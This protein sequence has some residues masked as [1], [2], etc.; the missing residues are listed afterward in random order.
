[1]KKLTQ[2]LVIVIAC[3]AFTTRGL[4]QSGVLID[5]YQSPTTFTVTGGGAYCAGGIGVPVGVSNSE[6]TTSYQLY[7]GTYPMGTSVGAPI[8]GNTG[9]PITFGNQ[10]TGGDYYVIATSQNGCTTLMSNTATVTVN[11]IPNVTITA[12]GPTHFCGSGSVTLTA[13]ATGCTFQWYKNN[14]IL[15]GANL[16]TYV[17]NSAGVY[18][19]VAN[20]GTC[21]NSTFIVVT[22]DPLPTQFTVSGSSPT[23]C[24][25]SNGATIT[26]NGSQGANITY[27]L[28]LNGSAQGPVVGGNNSPLAW[29][30]QDDAGIYTVV[31]TDTT[32]CTATMLGS[33][34]LSMD[35]LPAAT[36]AVIGNTTVCA[37]S[38]QTYMTN[39]VANATSYSWSIPNGATIV[40]GQGTNIIVVTFGATGGDI[41]VSGHNTCGNGPSSTAT[42][43]VN[44]APII[45]ITAT[46]PS[47]CLGQNTDL[48]AGGNGTA[49]VWSTGGNTQIINVAPT[50]TTTYTV[51]VTGTNGC[52]NTATSVVTVNPLPTV[53]LT[54]PL[55]VCHDVDTVVLQ[56]YP[57]GGTYNGW[58]INGNMIHPSSMQAQ[59]YTYTYT[60]TDGNGCSNTATEDINI[61]PTP[62]V[63]F[64]NVSVAIFTDTPPFDLNGY[65]TPT[66]GTFSGPGITGTQFNPAIAGPGVHLIYYTYTHPITGCSATQSQYI[67]VGSV[68][69]DEVIVE[70]I[71]IYPNPVSTT[72]N[73]SGINTEEIKGIKVMNAIGNVVFETAVED[74]TM[75]IDFSTFAPGAYMIGFFDADG[76]FLTRS[77]IKGQ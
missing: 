41:T 24:E 13:T 75:T 28:M 36:S 15:V 62:P 26:L 43:T 54:I 51:T 3:F 31:A 67:S 44:A 16:P 10:L 45:A 8:M 48:M 9:N 20:N 40:S 60:Y 52:T 35:P 30:N 33:W 58:G 12:G 14:N 22:V 55:A 61:N 4:S 50:M 18:S 46:D 71:K 38:T 53:T 25:N 47:L 7:R 29:A 70:N 19:V 32:G 34:A 68:G 65:V 64:F 27:Q 73:F 72:L 1:M 66:G 2:F 23:F 42:I 74:M 39:V 76:N 63:T 57:A 49:F 11:A 69:I 59:L 37:G 5:I 77:I 6:T 17:A 21:T 56:G